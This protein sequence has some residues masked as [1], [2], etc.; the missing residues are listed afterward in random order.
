MDREALF[1]DLPAERIAQTPVEPRDHCR[2]LI[3]NRQTGERVDDWFFN[4]GTHLKPGDVLVFNQSKV[5]PAR[6]HGHK[7][8]GGVVEVVLLKQESASQWQCLVGGKI[9]DAQ[10][11]QFGELLGTVHKPADQTQ[12]CVITFN[13]QGPELLQAIQAIGSMPTPPYIKQVLANPDLYQ[14]VYAKDLGS[15]AAPTAG[16]HFTQ[17][18]LEALNKQGVQ[19][20]FLTLHVGLGTFQPVKTSRVEEHHMHTEWFSI[21]AAAYQ[22]ILAAKK[23]GRR[24]IAVG[25]TSVRVLESLA[26]T[27]RPRTLNKQ[28]NT[29]TGETNI[30]ILPGYPFRVIDGLITN[31]HTPYSTL[32]ALVYAFG[33]EQHLRE[34]YQHAIKNQYRFFSFGD[35]MFI[36]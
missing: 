22:R 34:A 7:E 10:T 1:F 18:L 27:L 28:N 29:I 12:S 26:D 17:P 5:L 32:L 14:T 15:A 2:L 30:F 16:L 4:L 36:H 19:T 6:L 23:Q 13:K 31:F 21:D 8:S 11:V 24:V 20:E 33:G 25:T 9:N 3:V 35:A